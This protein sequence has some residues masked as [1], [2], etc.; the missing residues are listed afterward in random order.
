MRVYR[1]LAVPKI[2]LDARTTRLRRPRCRH[3]SRAVISVHRIPP[4]RVV[5]CATPLLSGETGQAD[6]S[7]L[8]DALSGIFLREGMDRLLVICPPGYFVAAVATGFDLRAKRSS[9]QQLRA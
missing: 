9:S 3:S 2:G 8:P 7:D 1:I 5:T 6:I 4:Q